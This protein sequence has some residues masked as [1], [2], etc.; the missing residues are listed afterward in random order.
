MPRQVAEQI[1]PI[2][3]KYDINDP[4][5]R[6]VNRLSKILD[7]HPVYMAAATHPVI[8]DALAALLGPLPLSA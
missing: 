8:L 2:V 6:L 3:W 7:R 1:E 4:N 5:K